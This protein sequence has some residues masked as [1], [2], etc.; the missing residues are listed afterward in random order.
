MRGKPLAIVWIDGLE[1]RENRE[2]KRCEMFT[3]FEENE[4]KQTFLRK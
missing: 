2:P 3:F 4:S 1:G